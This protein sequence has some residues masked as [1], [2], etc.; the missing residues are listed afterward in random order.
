MNKVAIFI[1]LI[2][3]WTFSQDPSQIDQ[4][5]LSEYIILEQSMQPTNQD[6]LIKR[7]LSENDITESRYAEIL[8]AGFQGKPLNLS[9]NEKKLK[10]AIQVINLE[11]KI[12][13]E[14]KLDIFLSDIGWSKEKLN[15]LLKKYNDNQSF[16]ENIHLLITQNNE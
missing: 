5:N 2:P 6:S 14:K 16:R 10:M 1:L 15:E 4:S 3:Y 12:K 11:A 8:R 9:E 13:N 7:L